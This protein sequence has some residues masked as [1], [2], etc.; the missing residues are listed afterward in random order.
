M[1][2]LR[3]IIRLLHDLT[4]D[5]LDL[6]KD[7]IWLVSFPLLQLARDLATKTCDL[8]I[9]D[10]R[11]PLVSIVCSK[12]IQGLVSWIVCNLCMFLPELNSPLQ[13]SIQRCLLFT[14]VGKVGG[15]L[16]VNSVMTILLSK[17]SECT[18]AFSCQFRRRLTNLLVPESFLMVTR[19]Y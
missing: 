3:Y 16:S 18:V 5:L 1:W 7:Q 14:G 6:N 9:G 11:L 10:L 12:K 8:Y 4:S 15:C 19:S 13:V 2:K 17:G